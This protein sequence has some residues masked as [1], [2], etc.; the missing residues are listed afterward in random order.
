MK[1]LIL[2]AVSVLLAAAAAAQPA[3][4]DSTAKSE[5]LP[6]FTS[7]AVAAPLDIVFVRVPDTQ[8]PKIVYDT[9]GS[10]TTRF[11]FEV[12][13]KQLRIGERAD[14]RRTERTSVRVYY[15][16]VS[17]FSIVDAAASFEGTLTVPLLDLTVGGRATL[18]A[19]LDVKD[20]RMELTGHSKAVLSGRVRYLSLLVSTGEVDAASLE[21]MSAQVNA[22]GGGAV[23]LT[24]TD[25]LEATTSTKGTISYEGQPA[26]VRGGTKFLG[27]D[28]VHIERD[29]KSE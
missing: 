21:T 2:S 4:A 9:K 15:N 23:T 27:G 7:V 3:P 13:D 28:I 26:I 14:A 19:A 16:D 24:V 11:K 6:S 5:W 22:T 18:A 1:N 17:D 29:T 20:L 25:R 10:Y 8:A 12:K